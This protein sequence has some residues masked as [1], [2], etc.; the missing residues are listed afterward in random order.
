[1]TQ[2]QLRPDL[3]VRY[4]RELSGGE[5]QRV[6]IARALAA[7]PEVVI[8]DE[9]TSALDVSV[10]AEILDLLGDLRNELGLALL[11]ISHD[12]A[13]VGR[14]ADR[15]VVLDHGEVCEQGD[16]AE[17]LSNPTHQTTRRLIAASRTLSAELERR[18]A[19]A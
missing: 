18:A 19:R 2:V 16:T 6:A 7:R 8:C 3:G 5:R 14:I 10:Q 13:V 17:V 15:I 12:L 4:P 9:I 11:F 1:L